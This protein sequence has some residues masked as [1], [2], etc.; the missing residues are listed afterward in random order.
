[1]QA[2]V[3][4]VA[5]HIL[6]IPT[7][8]PHKLSVAVMEHQS[9]VLVR[10]K[11]SDGIEGI[12][13]ATTIGGLNYGAESPESI[14]VNI[15]NYIAPLL[16]GQPAYNP[17]MLALRV[18]KAVKSNHFAKS[19]VETALYDALGKRLGVPVAALLGGAVRKELE[20][21]WTLA[22]GDTHKDIAEAQEMLDTRRHNIFKLKVGLRPFKE[23]LRHIA[24][25]KK[26]VGDDVS[27]RID[28][29]QG[30]SE[31]Q[32]LRALRPLADAGVDLVEQPIHEKNHAGLGRL[33]GLG[34]LPIMA[35][36]ALKGREDGFAL[37][38]ARGADVFAIKIEQAGGLRGA[39][40]LMG[41]AQAADIALYGGTM[42]E[43]P[44]STMAAAHLFSTVGRLEWG[45]ELFGPLLMKDDILAEPL[46]YSDFTLKLP[47]GPGLGIVLDEDKVRHYARG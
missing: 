45:T 41:I 14:K 24:A 19:A 37:A 25:I 32:A 5:T 2:T 43:G 26:A 11:T 30:W 38:A 42:L 10:I 13:E 33:S 17:G 23:D 28:V 39:Q 22:S 44:V 40:D 18:A 4:E 16:I 7:I 29:N 8:R 15:D 34:I 21:A 46:D 3:V 27:V 20:V 6:D 35:D 31:C 47:Q 36:E 1:M 9:M 12:G